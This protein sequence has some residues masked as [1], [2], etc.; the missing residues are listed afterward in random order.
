M[1]T[2]EKI[3]AKIQKIEIYLQKIKALG[4]VDVLEIN[5]DDQKR[6]ALERFL[7]L[8]TDSV[9]SLLEMFIAV[10]N[11]PSATTYTE[12]VYILHEKKEI[13]E[14]QAELLFDLIGFRNVLSH[15][16]EKLKLETLV[17][18]ANNGIEE[19]VELLKF[20]KSKI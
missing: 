2:V 17:N 6:A 7:Y 12:N 3:L 19:I 9:I 13:S 4:K 16:Y 8:A 14:K 1:S 10:K 5:Q 15:D 20:F 11:Y 18:V